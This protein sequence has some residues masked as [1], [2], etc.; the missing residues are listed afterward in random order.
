[1]NRAGGRASKRDRRSE[2]VVGT[3]AIP[4]SFTLWCM[5]LQ[6]QY[7]PATGT[8]LDSFWHFHLSLSLIWWLKF[9]GL[10]VRSCLHS[11]W[12]RSLFLIFLGDSFIT[13]NY[14][15]INLHKSWVITALSAIRVFWRSVMN[16]EC[17]EGMFVIEFY[18]YL[19]WKSSAMCLNNQLINT[20]MSINNQ[21]VKKHLNCF[22]TKKGMGKHV[23]TWGF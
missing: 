10:L 8:L 18:S 12:F 23:T 14:G 3:T 9:F 17:S 1:M 4:R 21:F 7:F 22:P 6:L 13:F 20:V 5:Q 15:G 19:S 11:D 2:D 16:D